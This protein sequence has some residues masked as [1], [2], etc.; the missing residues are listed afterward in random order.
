MTQNSRND[1]RGSVCACVSVCVHECI[2]VYEY[3]TV[4]DLPYFLLLLTLSGHSQT[5]R[6]P[7]STDFP[8][9]GANRA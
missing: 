1:W 6:I 3:M 8:E 9:S 7:V 4:C 2:S 5:C